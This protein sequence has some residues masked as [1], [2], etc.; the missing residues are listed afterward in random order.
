MQ[1]P[2]AA[3]S[4]LWMAL[5]LLPVHW[6][7]GRHAAAE[8]HLESSADQKT[9]HPDGSTARSRSWL[10]PTQ[11]TTAHHAGINCCYYWP[12]SKLTA[13]HS[14]PKSSHPTWAAASL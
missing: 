14:S 2:L 10:S 7:V 6:F 5:R 11:L 12:R 3:A 13:A 9:G 4:C 1:Q 8:M